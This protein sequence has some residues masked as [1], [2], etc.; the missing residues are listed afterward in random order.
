M[1]KAEKIKAYRELYPSYNITG[2][3][4][5]TQAEIQSREHYG[6]YSLEDLYANPS[7][8]KKSSYASLMRQY[9]PQRVLAVAGN[10]MTYSVLLVAE[11][12]V[13]MHITRDNNYL[14]EV[15]A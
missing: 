11:N 14:V 6:Y 2:V 5:M 10:S 4:T 3:K 15:E 7:E 8:A 12:G 13:T 9:N 1:T